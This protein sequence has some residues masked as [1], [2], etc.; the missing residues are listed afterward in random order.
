MKKRLIPVLL[1]MAMLLGPAACGLFQSCP[2]ALPYFAIEGLELTHQRFDEDSYG[3]DL[4]PDAST[5]CAGYGLHTDFESTYHA[6]LKDFKG[7]ANLYALSCVESGY[8]G[9][10]IG[11]DTLYLVTLEDYNEQ[12]AKND[13]L[14][15]IIMLNDWSKA[16]RFY[17]LDEYLAM[18]E[19]SVL[20]PA[21]TIKLADGPEVS[22]AIEFELVYVLTNGEEFKQKSTTVS[23]LAE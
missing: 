6:G 15:E 23:L 7:G 3:D 5:S 12:Y 22:H 4:L 20:M 11:V 2:E 13:T 14:N 18:N 19:E 16:D 21:F 1:V 8:M 9:S 17:S 10:A